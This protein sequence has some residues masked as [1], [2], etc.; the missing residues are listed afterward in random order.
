MSRPLITSTQF[1]SLINDNDVQY[2]EFLGRTIRDLRHENA[3]LDESIID[4]CER[5]VKVMLDTIYSY[6]EG[7]TPPTDPK[8][9]VL[10]SQISDKRN[11]IDA[12]YALKVV[13][14]SLTKYGWE[15]FELITGV[16]N[17]SS[18]DRDP[19]PFVGTY[20]EFQNL[21][22]KYASIT[23]QDSRELAFLTAHKSLCNLKKC[24]CIAM[25]DEI[26]QT[27]SCSNHIDIW[28]DVFRDDDDMITRLE[29]LG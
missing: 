13:N 8:I 6:R 18:D 14:D 10:E 27:A 3:T 28:K 11:F 12:C 23:T 29:F 21:L 17:L 16:V 9:K 22:R 19:I 4:G 2:R 5:E 20:G 26:V 25:R 1:V 7:S 24:D 15:A